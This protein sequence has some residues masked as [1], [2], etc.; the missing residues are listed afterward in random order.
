V[1]V[2][3]AAVRSGSF[4]SDEVWLRQGRQSRRMKTELDRKRYS[5]TCS[6]CAI[7][8]I[9]TSIAK[10]CVC[11]DE[12][13]PLWMSHSALFCQFATKCK[14]CGESHHMLLNEDSKQT[15]SEKLEVLS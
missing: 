9:K 8:A 14:V 11:C 6:Q 2:R 12:V 7:C 1:L 10:S 4:F 5:M 13:Q 3:E 15:F